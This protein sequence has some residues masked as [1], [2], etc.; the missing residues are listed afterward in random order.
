MKPGYKQ[1][2]IG[3]IPQDW[4]MKSIRDFASIK[5]GPFGTLLKADEYS[6]SEGVPLIS[7]G[8]VGIGRFRITENTP[9]VPDKVVR[10]LPQYVLRAGDIV[11]GR[12]GAVDRSAL[13]TQSEDGW[14]LGSDGISVRPTVKCHPPYLAA[15]FQRHEIRTWLLHNAIGTTMSSLNQGVLSRVQIPYAPIPEQRAIADALSDMDGLLSGLDRLIA[16]KRDLKQATMGRLLTGQIR[17]P[18]FHHKWEEGRLGDAVEKL[19]GGGTPSRS[20]LAFWGNDIPWATVKDFATFNPHQTQEAITRLGLNNSASHL[21]PAGTLIASTRMALGRAVIYD[22]DVAINQ[23][24]KAIILKPN[25]SARFLYYWFEF[26]EKT[27]DALGSGSTVKGISIAEL[28][29]IPF[30]RISL[31]EQS[32]IAAVLTEMDAELAALELR[33]EKTRALKQAM[34]Q[35]LLTGRTRLIE[36]DAKPI[37]QKEEVQTEGR[38]A[39]VHFLRSVLAAEII[40]RLHE[41]PTFG[42]VKFEKMIFLVE[43]L[44]DVDTGSTYHR[45]AAGPYDNRALRSIDSQ[46]R[47]QQWFDARKE[48]E[49][50]RYV[51]MANRGGHKPYFERHFSEIGDAFGKVLDTFKALDTERCEIV[52]TLLAAWSDL[53]REKGAV[54]DESIVHEVLN[55]WHESKRRISEDRWLKALGWMRDKGFVPKGVTSP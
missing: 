36:P 55:N 51:P 8:E 43:H 2:E 29:S 31:L 12:K 45:K 54:S 1:T 46:L 39:N 11:F 40:D 10:R 53:L 49:R 4:E 26:N 22:V 37:E 6:G 48:G 5:T 44:C 9:L 16:K 33:R 13:V 7:V 52:A 21:I 32:A 17:I 24:L 28:K 30:A 25:N 15:Q 38:K 35:E 18:G 27:V 14:F 47:A 20:N 19:I 3:V 23:D 34:M 41:Q 42:H 50:Y